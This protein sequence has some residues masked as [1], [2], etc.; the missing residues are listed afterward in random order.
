[1]GC[2]ISP[3]LL[4]GFG[5]Q[6]SDVTEGPGYVH[7]AVHHQGYGFYRPAAGSIGLVSEPVG[8]LRRQPGNVLNINLLERGVSLRLMI[9]TDIWPAGLSMYGQERN[10]DSETSDWHR[11]YGGR[12]GQQGSWLPLH[13]VPDAECTGC[14]GAKSP[15]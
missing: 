11:P 5:V 2:G 10:E 1:M 6:R 14:E 7:A 15:S 4:T 13:L 8:P 3:K 12:P 9:V